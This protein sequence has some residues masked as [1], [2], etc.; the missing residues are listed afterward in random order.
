MD[1]IRQRQIGDCYFMSAIASIALQ[2]ADDI[3]ESIVDMGDHTY[4][5]RMWNNGAPVYYRVDDNVPVNKSGGMIRYGA[6]SLNGAIWAPMLEKAFVF[7]EDGIPGNYESLNN[8]APSSA[9]NALGLQ[10]LTFGNPASAPDLKTIYDQLVLDR[11]IAVMADLSAGSFDYGDKFIVNHVYSVV[12]VD[13][14]NQTITLRNPW[15]NDAGGVSKGGWSDGVDD[16]YV[17]FTAAEFAA[18]FDMIWSAIT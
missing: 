12:D 10:Y 16:G 11:A 6:P 7:H 5:I 8:G 17:T 2:K 4:A 15:G 9:Y 14:V 18:D 1:D 13:L 3:R